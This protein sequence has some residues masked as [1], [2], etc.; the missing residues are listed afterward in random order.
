VSYTLR[1]AGTLALIYGSF[2]G[3]VA[4]LFV[5]CVSAATLIYGAEVNAV[6]IVAGLRMQAA[7]TS[8]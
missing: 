5:L 8:L 6:L 7:R 1:S 4:A 3:V 2:A